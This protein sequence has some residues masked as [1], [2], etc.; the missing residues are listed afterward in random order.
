MKKTLDVYYCNTR[1]IQGI[2]E[3]QIN[4]YYTFLSKSRQKKVS[5]FHHKSDK[6]LSLTAELLCKKII[7]DIYHIDL[8]DLHFNNN[9][10]GKPY[11]YKYNNIDF[12]ISHTEN[13]V[14]FSVASFLIGLDIELKDRI[15]ANYPDIANNHFSHEE[16]I[17]LYQ[18][19]NPHREFIKIWTKKEA[20]IKSI[21][22]G[23]HAPLNQINTCNMPSSIFIKSIEYD[24]AIISACSH[25]SLEKINII[26]IKIEDLLSFYNQ[27]L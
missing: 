23:L 7:N 22:L 25:S 11:L 5:R 2:E 3:N 15:T 8:K 12:S 4:K 9:L 27:R 14:I 21:G 13:R 20:Y 19:L 26:S 16:K 6:I 17:S 24:S 1:Q 10:Y 18:S